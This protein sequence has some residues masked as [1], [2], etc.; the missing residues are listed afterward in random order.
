[1]KCLAVERDGAERPTLALKRPPE[2][3]FGC[4]GIPLGAEQEIDGFSL[5]FDDAPRGASSAC[6]AVPALFIAP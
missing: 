1:M 6:E 3:R 4:G 5:F 2:E